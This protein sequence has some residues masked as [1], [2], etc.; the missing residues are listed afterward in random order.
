MI[1]IQ[2]LGKSFGVNPV[3]T[4]L[5]NID[6]HVNKNDWVTVLGTSG[7]GKTTLLN[8][9]GGVLKPSSGFVK[10]DGTTLNKMDAT[11]LQE[12]RRN[13]IGFIYQ[14]FKLFNQYTVLENVMVPQ[15]PYGERK[16]VEKKAT[17]LIEDVGLTHRISHFPQELSGGEKQRVAI[18]R[19]LLNNPDILLCDEPTGNLDSTNTDNIMR[20]IQNLHKTGITIIFVTHD[21]TLVK[22]S[23]R[24]LTL[25]DGMVKEYT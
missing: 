6:L 12:Y 5:N 18:A 22:Y 13:K 9:I 1:N 25:Q 17:Q 3:T 24:I 19:A 11:N 14:D 15:L 21:E 7:S 23:N 4:A 16:E 8:I 20:F 10:I 2:N